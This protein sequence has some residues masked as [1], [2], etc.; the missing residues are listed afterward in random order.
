MIEVKGNK[1]YADNYVNEALVMAA[2]QLLECFPEIEVSFDVIG[3]TL[4]QCLAHQLYDQMDQDTF[5]ADIDYMMYKCRIYTKPI[6]NVVTIEVHYKDALNCT[7]V[8]RLAKA[9]TKTEDVNKYIER[10]LKS[11]PDLKKVLGKLYVE[12]DVFD[13][14]G[15][16]RIETT[17]LD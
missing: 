5:S 12:G 8:Q 13:V 9:F 14:Y 6:I 16:I 4:H 11:K 17:T 3:R 15:D 7:R 1:I 10:T 2:S